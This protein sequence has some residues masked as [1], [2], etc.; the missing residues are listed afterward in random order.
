MRLHVLGV[1]IVKT[2]SGMLSIAAW[3]TVTDIS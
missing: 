3:Q 1:T 2:N